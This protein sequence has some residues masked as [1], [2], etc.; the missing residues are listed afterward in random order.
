MKKSEYQTSSFSEIET[1]IKNRS[2]YYESKQYEVEVSKPG[3]RTNPKSLIPGGSIVYL[4][5]HK[6]KREMAYPNV[7][8]I[9]IYVSTILDKFKDG[10]SFINQIDEIYALM[11]DNTIKEVSFKK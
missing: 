2:K 9:A 3:N 5:D 10:T 1:F 11:A 7:K 6:S 4:V 8:N